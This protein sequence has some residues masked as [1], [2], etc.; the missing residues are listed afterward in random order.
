MKMEEEE[1]EECEGGSHSSIYYYHLSLVF[2]DTMLQTD[3]LCVQ[4]LQP[5]EDKKKRNFPKEVGGKLRR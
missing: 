4:S 5:D 1:C 3:V 2:I